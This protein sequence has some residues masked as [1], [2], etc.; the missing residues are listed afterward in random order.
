MTIANFNI[1]VSEFYRDA[2]GESQKRTHWFKAVCFGRQAEIAAEYLTKGS[3]VAIQGSLSTSE[4][5]D[6]E[7]RRHRNV[8]IKVNQLEFMS[9]RNDSAYP[10]NGNGN[11][12]AQSRPPEQNRQPAAPSNPPP[13]QDELPPVDEYEKDIPF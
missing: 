9:S 1:A 2:A 13:Q 10:G 8:E 11:G 5:E 4:W 3:K 12:Q 6:H 7:G